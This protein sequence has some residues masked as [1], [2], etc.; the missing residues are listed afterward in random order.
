MKTNEQKFLALLKIAKN[1]G[2]K[3]SKYYINALQNGEIDAT[4]CQIVEHQIITKY[5]SINDIVGNFEEGK[6][7]FIDALQ[8]ANIEY[9]RQKEKEFVTMLTQESMSKNWFSLVTPE[10]LDWF[11]GK[12]D[13]LINK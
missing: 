7:S 3:E 6:T 11:L 8:N 13:F 1:N 12:Y 2:F 10:R 5:H 9:C 4:Y